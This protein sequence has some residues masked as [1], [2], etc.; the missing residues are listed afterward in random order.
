MNSQ[1]CP[2]LVRRLILG[3]NLYIKKKRLSAF[4][5]AEAGVDIAAVEKL[6]CRAVGRSILNL[7]ISRDMP[8]AA[9]GLSLVTSHASDGGK[10]GRLLRP[11]NI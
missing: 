2:L 4:L 3:P 10:R 9:F 7:A 6:G 1:F 11:N 8:V 5:L